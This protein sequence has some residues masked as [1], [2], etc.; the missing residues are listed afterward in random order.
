MRRILK[1]PIWIF[2]I[3]LGYIVLQFS[4]WL[5]LI[6]DLSAEVYPEDVLMKRFMMILGEGIVFL[7]IVIL[8]LLLIRKALKLEKGVMLQ[9]ENFLLSITHELKT[10]IASAQLNLQTLNRKDLPEDKKEKLRQNALN[11]MFR[12]NKLAN[13]LLIAKSITANNVFNAEEEINLSQ[14]AQKIVHD[15]FSDQLDGIK[16]SV[17]K[18][19]VV[20]GD[21]HAL[22][23]VISN[24]VDN[25]LKYGKSDENPIEISTFSDKNWAGVRIRDYGNG[26]PENKIPLVVRKFQRLENEMTRTSKGSGLG[27]YIA[28]EL[29]KKMGGDLIVENALP[30]GLSITIKLKKSE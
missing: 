25:A 11:D 26:I 2:Y 7:S 14:L 3:L 15:F 27:L 16:I 4:W 8:G 23:S 10:P 6:Y 22:T 28:N 17:D 20:K 24:L 21:E 5:I 18:K 12:L 30:S 19:A 1:N 9:Q 13:N 29:T